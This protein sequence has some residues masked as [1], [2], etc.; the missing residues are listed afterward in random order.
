M[1]WNSP[2]CRRI[3][4]EDLQTG[5]T[6]VGHVMRLAVEKG[7]QIA[8]RY[9]EA[10]VISADT[11]VLYRGQILGKPRDRED[12]FRILNTLSGRTHEVITAFALTNRSRS[13]RTPANMKAPPSPSGNCRRKQYPPISTANHPWTRPGRTGYRT[14]RQILYGRSTAASIMSP[15]SPPPLFWKVGQDSFR[16]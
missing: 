5:E 4:H 15:D 2:A 7:A 1:D 13:L 12:A 16:A 14:C 9:P 3:L 10:L 6:P 11:I 8:E